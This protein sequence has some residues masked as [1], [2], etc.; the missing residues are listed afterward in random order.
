MSNTVSQ[1]DALHMLLQSAAEWQLIARLL[2][3]PGEG[4][5]EEIAALA[6]AVNDEDL[7]ASAS[8]AADEAS[9]GLYI[10]TFGPG[11]P[12]APREVSYRET[13][14]LGHILAEVRGLYAAFGYEPTSL[15][16]P[17]HVAVMASFW[18]YLFFKQAY[19]E[20]AEQMEQA[21]VTAAAAA[22]FVELHLMVVAVPLADR[23][24]HCEV[25][26]LEHVGRAMQRRA[27]SP[28]ELPVLAAPPLADD[29][30]DADFTCA[31]DGP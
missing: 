16:P 22:R 27:G 28:Q 18:A 30:P 13:L 23:L 5:R 14:T 8:A 6:A 17:D 7:T 11:G 31:T 2:S 25:P 20:M 21:A 3:C 15:E 26:Y 1:P 4:W 10:A 24:A 9:E 29:S 12:A 19:A